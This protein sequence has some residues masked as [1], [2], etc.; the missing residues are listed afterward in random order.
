[1][2]PGE[3]KVSHWTSPVL[4]PLSLMSDTNLLLL[5]DIIGRSDEQTIPSP[6]G[7]Q[8][9][10][11]TVSYGAELCVQGQAP[12]ALPVDPTIP[13]MPCVGQCI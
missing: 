11:A 13:S 6:L 4:V 9:W 1:M 5:G 10:V 12:R 8:F 7:N 3:E 2:W